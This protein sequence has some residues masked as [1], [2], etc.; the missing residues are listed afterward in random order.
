M[1]D[2]QAVSFQ[3]SVD[4]QLRD[5]HAGAEIASRPMAGQTTRGN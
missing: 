3:N 5:V 1:G 4:L 2:R